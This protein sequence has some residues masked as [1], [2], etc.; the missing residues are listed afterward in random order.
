MLKSLFSSRWLGGR[1]AYE[2]ASRTH[3]ALSGYYAPRVSPQAALEADREPLSARVA[4]LSRNNPWASAAVRRKVDG[5]IGAGLNFSSRPDAISLGISQDAAKQLARQ[6]ESH[7]RASIEDLEHRCDAAGRLSGGQIMALALRHSLWHGD[8]LARL[9]FLPRGGVSNIAVELIH[10]Q[11]LAQPTGQLETTR[12]RDGIE[13]DRFGGPVAYHFLGA[14]P[15]DGLVLP[16]E[17]SVR[18][19]RYDRDGSRRVLHYF[20]AGD[21]GEIR[22]RSPVAPIVKKLRQ[23]GKFDEAELQ[24]ATLNATLAAFIESSAD[25]SVLAEL[26]GENDD[27]RAAAQYMDT[28]AVEREGHHKD[29]PIQMDGVQVMQLATGEKVNFTNPARPSSSYDAFEMAALR[30]IASAFDLSVEML[31]GDYSKLSY[32]GWRGAM[33]N[34]WRGFTCERAG[35]VAQFCRPWLAAVIEDGI[36]SGAIA[37]PKGAAS[38]WQRPTAYV[39]GQ[40]LGPGRGSADPAKDARALAQNLALGRTTLTQALAE[41]GIDYDDQSEQLAREIA[42]HEA[43][44]LVHPRLQ[45]LAGAA[46]GGNPAQSEPDEET[47]RER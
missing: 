6:I 26:L 12:F 19:P 38:F 37:P 17:K 25:H 36:A 34:V 21:I 4:D 2:A 47:G 23:L 44:G 31:T 29:H 1:G 30:N 8:A 46:S 32:S 27:G 40:W 39:A 3:P 41:D 5:I 16:R 43:R 22:G 7:W 28:L 14:H 45:P 35:F 20:Y 9:R 33:L 42:D 24:A 15:D 18:V 11:Q 10:S 13:L